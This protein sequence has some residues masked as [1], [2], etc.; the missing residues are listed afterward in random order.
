M[1]MLGV[2]SNIGKCDLLKAGYKSRKIIDKY[3][4]KCY[5]FFAIVISRS[6]NW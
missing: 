2:F 5:Y 6:A 3:I 1:R 4:K